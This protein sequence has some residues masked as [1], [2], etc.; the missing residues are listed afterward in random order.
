MLNVKNS[1]CFKV[2]V[3]LE[4]E[5]NFLNELED[6]LLCFY[7]TMHHHLIETLYTVGLQKNTAILGSIIEVEGDFG[8]S[9]RVKTGQ[10]TWH[11]VSS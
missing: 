1:E 9:F 8:A 6:N 2:T 4:S 3:S 11:S 5:P 7:A 10:F